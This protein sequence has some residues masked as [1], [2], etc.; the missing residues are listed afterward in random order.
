MRF[1]FKKPNREL[2]LMVGGMPVFSRAW[3]MENG[4]AKPFDQIV[5]D[6]PIGSGPYKIGPVRFGRDITYVRDPNYWARDLPVRRGHVQLRPHHVQ[7]L[8]GQHGAARGVQG[9]RV[10][11]DA[12]SISAGD[13]ARRVQRQALRHR[14]AG[15]AARSSTSSRHGFQGYVLNMPQPKF[16]DLRVRQALG[17]ALDFEWMNRQLFYGATS[18]CSGLFGNSD[19]AANGLAVA[20]RTGAARALRG[21]LPPR[22]V[23][24]DVRR[25]R[26]PTAPGH[27]C[28]PTC[29]RRR[30]C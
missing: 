12:R 25:R 9:R 8:Q 2:P 5:M 24:P 28:A 26:A 22:G 21:K 1:G 11:H 3:G 14:R 27:R 30:R 15:Q 13:W 6:M 19:C 29:A 20:G 16:Q 18:G 4:K 23:R 10:R 17:L 7:D